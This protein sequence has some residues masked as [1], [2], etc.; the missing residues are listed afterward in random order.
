MITQSR[1]FRSQSPEDSVEGFRADPAAT[2]SVDLSACD[3]G[4]EFSGLSPTRFEDSLL[5]PTVS[6]FVP[7]VLCTESICVD[8]DINPT[9]ITHEET[10]TI[11]SPP[12]SSHVTDTDSSNNDP[13]DSDE[14]T[15]AETMSCEIGRCTCSHCDYGSNQGYVFT[16]INMVLI[17]DI[18][19]TWCYERITLNICC[20][21][22]CLGF[23]DMDTVLILCTLLSFLNVL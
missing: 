2:P 19:S 3:L 21:L 8:P 15:D 18:P 10:L 7:D 22:S 20:L 17:S 5:C 16:V 14:N 23:Q 13:P 9:H 12:R 4:L 6:P 11:S 1:A